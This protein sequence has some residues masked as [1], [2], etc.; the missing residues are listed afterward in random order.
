MSKTLVTQGLLEISMKKYLET[1]LIEHVVCCGES[2]PDARPCR[3]E[4]IL[5]VREECM[6]CGVRFTFKQTGALFVKDGKTYHIDR[7]YQMSQAQKAGYDYD[8]GK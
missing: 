2:G 7:K 5:K 1:G 6:R 8:P 4:W 3:F